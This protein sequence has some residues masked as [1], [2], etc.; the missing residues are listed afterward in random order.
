MSTTTPGHR[1]QDGRQS[2]PVLWTLRNH[3][4]RIERHL[5]LALRKLARGSEDSADAGR[6]LAALR[7]SPEGIWAFAKL[8]RLLAEATRGLTLYGPASP[9]VSM[10]E[11]S[12]LA[13]LHRLSLDRAPPPG[14][15]TSGLDRTS[16]LHAFFQCAQAM[17]QASI[18]VGPRQ[19]IAARQ[20]RLEAEPLVIG[21]SSSYRRHPARV[22]RL[23]QISPSIRRITLAGDALHGLPVT[24]AAQWI[25]LFLPN[26]SDPHGAVG[27]AYTVRRHRPAAGEIDVDVVLHEAAGPLSQWAGG[28][29]RTGDAVQIAGP[30]GGHDIEARHAWMVLAGDASAMPAMAS[31]I[32]HAP[33]STPIRVLLTLPSQDDEHVLPHRANVS[34]TS[35][36][37]RPGDDGGLLALLA[38]Q[39]LP[40]SQPGLVWIAAEAAVAQKARRYLAMHACGGRIKSHDVG[41]WKHG[42]RDHKDVAAG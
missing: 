35:A 11:L 18:S 14:A 39:S 8:S 40:G 42:T 20:R 3:C 16:L 37:A 41:Y 27:R 24:R 32:E 13:T 19:F 6:T 7:I 34:V 5:I 1:P 9:F 4:T 33:E 31:L 23:R 25:K 2:P 21:A 30:R 38:G 36:L 15:A 17:N 28:T 29:A 12:V 10:D 26:D 22:A